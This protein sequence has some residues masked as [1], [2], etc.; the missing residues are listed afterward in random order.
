MKKQTKSTV[1]AGFVQGAAILGIAGLLVKIIGAVYR[2]PLANIVGE[3]GMAYYEVAY[4]YYSWLLVI[5]SAGLPTAISKLVSERIALGDI[6]GAKRVFRAALRLLF[7]IG[8]V[9]AVLLFALSSP[10]ANLSGAAPARYSLMALSPALLFVSVMCAYRGYLQGMQCMTGTAISQIV[11]QLIK[12]IF[13]FGLA[14]LF[15]KMRPDAP[16]LAAMGALIG[17][18]VSELVALAVIKFY[19]DARIRNRSLPVCVSTKGAKS[20]LRGS[21]I[22]RLLAIAIPITIGASIMPVTGIAD[23][24][25]IINFLEKH[26]IAMGIAEEIANENARVAYTVLRSYVTPLINMP[27]VLTLSLSM[28]LVPAISQAV[29]R[30]EKRIVN[31]ASRTGIKLAMFIG[32]PCAAGLFILGGPIMSLLYSAVRNNQDRF[33]QA[34]QV[35]YIAA[36]GVLFL[37]LVQTLTGIIQGLGKPRVPVYFLALGGIVKV[38]SML[39]LMQFTSMGILGAALSTVLCYAVAGIADTVYV[40]RKTR[41]NISYTDTFAKPLFSSIAMG[42]AVFAV[43]ALGSK[44]GHPTL[45]TLASLCVGVAVYGGLMILLRPFSNS[46]LEFLPKK[47]LFRRIF[48]VR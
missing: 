1:N 8:I 35:M 7:V 19:Y 21:I 41:M 48:R 28:S 23:S 17:V 42:F 2:I 29:T 31:A 33:I 5:S 4:P 12:L 27:A 44:L 24:V 22:K 26:D 43:Y 3:S 38:V 45:A 6:V 46:D 39:V 25:F 37:S 9:T 34:Q 14:F 11:E 13:G 20:R 47:D 32:A 36:V 15:V 16:E 30:K 10:I 40:I 18:S